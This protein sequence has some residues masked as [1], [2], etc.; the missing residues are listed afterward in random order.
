MKYIFFFAACFLIAVEMTYAGGIVCPEG[1]KPNGEQTPE[2]SEAWCELKWK[3]KIVLHGP[4]RSWWSNG[5]L[6]N[7]GQYE[8]GKAVGKW[9][10]WYET[11]QKQ[12]EET[13]FNGK[14]VSETLWNKDGSI[15]IS[16]H[17]D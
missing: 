9:M 3:G 7:V 5:K 14:K 12:A 17:S 6:G 11:G 10:A 16:K 4:Y 8:K 1:T 2:V 15:K 13:F